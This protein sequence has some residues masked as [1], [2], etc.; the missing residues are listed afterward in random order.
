M[1]SGM[2]HLTLAV[3]DLQSS[4]KFYKSILGMNLRAEWDQGAYL[5]VGEFWVCLSLDP[6]R[7][8]IQ[9]DYTHYAFSIQQEDFVDFRDRLKLM[10]VKTWRDNTSEGDSFFFLDPNGHKLEAHVGNLNSRLETCKKA[11]YTGMKFY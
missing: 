6:K 10:D 5:S 1:L 2:N 9:A 11:P 3:V 8:G 7:E 4:V